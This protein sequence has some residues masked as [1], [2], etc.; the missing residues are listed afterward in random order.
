MPEEKIIKPADADVK[1]PFAPTAEDFAEI[2]VEGDAN[3]A[4]PVRKAAV[5]N[6]QL[7]NG[8][9]PEGSAPPIERLVEDL[10]RDDQLN[11]G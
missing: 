4:P 10:T 8:E 5:I 1:N 6:N 2:A 9:H 3:N 7:V 11:D